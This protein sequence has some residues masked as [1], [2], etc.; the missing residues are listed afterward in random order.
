MDDM[1]MGARTLTAALTELDEEYINPIVF[2]E[3]GEQD[4]TVLTSAPFEKRVFP[5]WVEAYHYAY[6][7][8][9]IPFAVIE[10][11]QECS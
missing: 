7:V 9:R 4:W 2:K 6:T 10:T 11:I 8:A 3:P 5:S 1:T